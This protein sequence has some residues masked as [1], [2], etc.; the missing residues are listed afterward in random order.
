MPTLTVS[1]AMTTFNGARFLPAQLESIESQTRAPD[2]LVIFDDC[3][4]DTTRQILGNFR[5][6]SRI[7][8]RVGLNTENL[9][10]I[11]NFEKAVSECAGELLF[12]SDQDDVWHRD[13]IR[14]MVSEF[15]A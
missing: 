1:V 3:S 10:Y 6:R 4:T 12:L 8:T 11:R 2:E 5:D 13:K 9:G 15:E 7:P 14:K